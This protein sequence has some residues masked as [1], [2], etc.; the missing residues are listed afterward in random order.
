VAELEAKV[1]ELRGM[2]CFFLKAASIGGLFIFLN[3][4]AMSAIG[5]KRTRK[6]S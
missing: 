1:E 5:T 4:G 2:V 6:L 3:T